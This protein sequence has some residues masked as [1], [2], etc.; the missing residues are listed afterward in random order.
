M[1]T[2]AKLAAE[3]AA[4]DVF[5]SFNKRVLPYFDYDEVYERLR[6]AKPTLKP[7]KAG[8]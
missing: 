7:R 4:R 3:N 2:K 8:V 5:P 1:L 6:L